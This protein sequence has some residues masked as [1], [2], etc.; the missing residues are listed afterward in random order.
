MSSFEVDA[1][2]F[3]AEFCP[4]GTPCWIEMAERRG[5]ALTQLVTLIDFLR[6]R[7]C[8]ESGVLWN[9][10]TGG[11][12][13]GGSISLHNF[14]LYHLNER[15][16]MPCTA[17]FKCSFVELVASRAEDQQPEFFVSHWWGEPVV[18]FVMCLQHF[19]A[20]RRPSRAVFWVCAYA[21]N[22]H[23]LNGD[24]AD[25]PAE[26]S[27][28]RA[29]DLSKGTLMVLDSNATPF[30]RVWCAFEVLISLRQR[31]KTFDFVAF[32]PDEASI[33]PREPQLPEVCGGE[34]RFPGRADII[35]EGYVPGDH[36]G[37]GRRM[38]VGQVTRPPG[39]MDIKA[40][41]EASFP[42][43]I[44]LRA[45]KMSVQ[46]ASASI[47]ADRVHILS[48]IAGSRDLDANPPKDHPNY[49][50][51]NSAI[52]SRFA[53]AVIVNVARDHPE[54]VGS[55]IRAICSDAARAELDLQVPNSSFDD[56][57]LRELAESLPRGM[58][59]LGL[60]LGGTPVQ[61]GGV[62]ALGQSLERLRALRS[63]S[64]YVNSRTL[65]SKAAASLGAGVGALANLSSLTLLFTDT[66]VD[67]AGAESIAQGIASLRQLAYLQLGFSYTP[68]TDP[69][70]VSIAAALSGKSSLRHLRL[71]ANNT[72]VGSEA[73]AAVGQCL[74][75]LP[76]LTGVWL[77]FHG[78]QVDDGGARAVL[79]AAGCLRCLAE[80]YVNFAASR[81]SDPRLGQPVK[82][83]DALLSRLAAL[84]RE[85]P[86]AA[87]RSAVASCRG[88]CR[89]RRQVAPLP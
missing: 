64:L 25:N 10:A 85:A 59:S 19:V 3:T 45:I 13:G 1:H 41:R 87:P 68:V 52:R 47:D 74:A 11:A 48:A 76:A 20:A 7:Y 80:V 82:S 66:K 18:H 88:C 33:G 67:N 31:D 77:G 39:P 29:L 34:L 89:R 69:G 23:D 40:A 8:D 43:S 62:V 26:S 38:T 46:T 51:M 30:T 37:K 14:N 57:M 42:M 21:N 86:A 16:I 4:S 81:V 5:I 78:T 56:D 65:T 55:F 60:G 17:G 49:D 6:R 44:A 83:A 58:E 27:F 36:E 73:A 35:T 9:S 63:C 2:N 72:R 61:D 15:L 79:Q 71:T 32:V 22:Q 75:G 24:L 28:K 12:P 53:V 84:G 50:A 70:L 54:E